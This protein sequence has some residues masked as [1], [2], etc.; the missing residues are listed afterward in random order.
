MSAELAALA[1]EEYCYLT[2]TGRVT[3][4]PHTIE[5]WFSLQGD[6]L[7][8]LSGGRDR[9]DWVKN[10]RRTPQVTVRIA[11]S[12]FPGQARIVEDAEEDALA[13]RLLVE[14]YAPRY[15]GDL[16]GWRRTAL[17]VA[18]DIAASPR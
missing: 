14:K 2:T 18:I 1:G 10:V 5:I 6:T 13:R 9:S 17:P 11:D 4:R 3:G 12:A 8:L 7:Y 15:S 16:S